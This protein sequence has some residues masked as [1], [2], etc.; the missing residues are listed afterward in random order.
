MQFAILG[1]E[2]NLARA[3]LESIAS[4]FKHLTKEVSLFTPASAGFSI[5]HVGGM[6]KT[7]DILTSVDINTFNLELFS[8][9]LLKLI[10][11]KSQKITF[12]VSSYVENKNINSCLPRLSKLLKQELKSQQTPARF[13]LGRK[14]LALSAAEII[15][16]QLAKPQNFEFVLLAD[17]QS[18][19][20]GKTSAVQ[21]INAYSVRD[22]GKPCRNAKVGMLPPKLAQIMIN[23]SQTKNDSPVVDPFCGSGVILAEAMLLRRDG[24]G[25]DISPQMVDCTKTNLEWLRTKYSL[26]SKYYLNTADATVELDLPDGATIV[27]ETYL[28][29]PQL[30]FPDNKSLL[31]LKSETSRIILD[32]LKNLHEQIS[33]GQRA[34]ICLPFW[35]DGT[36]DYSLEIIDQILSLGYTM[37]QFSSSKADELRYRRASQIVG[38]QILVLTRK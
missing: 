23:L 37:S 25:A 16:N 6:I 33:T 14:G 27:T 32:F 12:A 28:G 21:D 8:K 35:S 15:Y 19:M 17:K 24:Y 3:E 2:T 20:V 36:R 10:E 7:G 9:E 5:N 26:K 31:V 29:R 30:S 18:L 22:H 13:V 1:R 38:R 4:N 34:V 11:S